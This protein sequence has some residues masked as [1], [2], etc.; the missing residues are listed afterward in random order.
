MPA[1]S[2]RSRTQRRQAERRE[3]RQLC[4]EL[5]SNLADL[6][7]RFAVAYSRWLK[8]TAVASE[9]CPLCGELV[10]VTPRMSEGETDVA[11]G[12]PVCML[13]VPTLET[14]G[15]GNPRWTVG[16]QART[17]GR[18]VSGVGTDRSVRSRAEPAD[19]QPASAHVWE[20]RASGR[21]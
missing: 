7:A 10:I 21:S 5:E 16:P 14:L 8:L 19:G 1:K 20:P 11:H 9:T 15:A 12:Q 18:G 17:H 6:A 3:R 13:W 2:Q 4:G